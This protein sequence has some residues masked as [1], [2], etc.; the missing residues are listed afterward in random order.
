MKELVVISGKGGTGK[1]CLTEIHLSVG[2][3]IIE[4]YAVNNCRVA[5]IA[6]AEIDREL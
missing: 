2:V 3:D 4:N 5:V 1:T 6:V